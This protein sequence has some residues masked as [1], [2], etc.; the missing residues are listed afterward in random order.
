[1][2]EAINGLQQVIT[3][4]NKEIE[5]LWNKIKELDDDKQGMHKELVLLKRDYE[6]ITRLYMDM[7]DMYFAVSRRLHD[8]EQAD[9]VPLCAR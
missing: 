2:D 8:Y 4:K 1:M 7:S 6:R 9:R 3:E 5:Q